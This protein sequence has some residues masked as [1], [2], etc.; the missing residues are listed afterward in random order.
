[1]KKIVFLFIFSISFLYSGDC[2]NPATDK[3]TVSSLNFE[4]CRALTE[5]YYNSTTDIEP[6]TDSYV[7][8]WY[9]EQYTNGCTYDTVFY[10]K[11]YSQQIYSFSRDYVCP[12]GQEIIN[13]VCAV[14]PTCAVGTLWNPLTDTCEYDPNTAD[15]DG[16]GIPDKCDPDYVDYLTMDCNS[17]GEA[18]GVDDD[19]DGDGI[20]NGNDP[21]PYVNGSALGTPETP[22]GASS[23]TFVN[24]VDEGS[25]SLSNSAFSAPDFSLNY[26]SNVYW[27]SCRQKCGVTLLTCPFGKAIKNG[28]CTSMEPDEGDCLGTK[29]CSI[30]SASMDEPGV[31]PFCSKRCYCLTL[32]FPIRSPDNLYY[33][34]QVS[35]SENA[36]D[37]T[38]LDNLRQNSDV[39]N[40]LPADLLKDSNATA[41]LDVSA[42]MKVALDSYAGS[43]EATQLELLSE[44]KIQSLQL[45][46]ANTNLKNIESALENFSATST[47]N[48][49]V[50]NGSLQGIKGGIDTSNGL[51]GQLVDGQT[52]G[53]TLLEDIKGLLDTNGTQ[54]DPG[55]LDFIS[56]EIGNI[57]SK[58]SIDLSSGGCSSISTV[59]TILNGRELVFLSQSTIDKLPV[60]EMKALIIFLF[61]I[62]GLMLVFR[63]N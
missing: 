37:T 2:Y 56:N 5:I 22:C 57:L 51:L 38:T 20:K 55:N 29:S 28:V 6:C 36:G 9:N 21:N 46:S 10:K 39:N 3:L 42:S 32:Q 35:C 43:K 54:D 61:T 15:G 52:E 7:V 14:P 16:D 17:D 41:S 27:D 23:Y 45:V 26:V 59:S 44:S 1:M 49:G 25:C 31:E 40:S 63:G 33:E 62:T 50:I 47:S 58:Y 24:G 11:K 4:Q 53:N 19:I 13:G 34:K 30:N 60:A 12:D 8:K 48:Q 18:N